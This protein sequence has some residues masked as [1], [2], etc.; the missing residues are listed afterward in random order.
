LLNL[1]LNRKYEENKELNGIS[2]DSTKNGIEYEI[3]RKVEKKVGKKGREEGREKGRAESLCTALIVN[4]ISPLLFQCTP[5]FS[6]MTPKSLLP[7][8]IM[9]SIYMMNNK[10]MNKIY[11]NIKI[12]YK[13]K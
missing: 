13:I 12:Q 8:K 6:R 3:E 9:P 2:L 4:I 10:K 5:G 1:N 7:P 11:L